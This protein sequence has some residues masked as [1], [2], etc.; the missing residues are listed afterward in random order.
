MTAIYRNT[1][2][3]DLHVQFANLT[4][5]LARIHDTP[6]FTEKHQRAQEI[7]DQLNQIERALKPTVQYGLTDRETQVLHLLAHGHTNETIGGI[8]SLSPLTV[9]THIRKAMNRMGVTSRV[10]AVAVATRLDLFPM[11]LP[12]PTG[13]AS[14]TSGTIKQLRAEMRE[15]GERTITERILKAV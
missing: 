5:E 4:L 10:Q 13:Q 11:T 15:R 6:G 2:E 8:L 7:Q 9:R 14:N 3:Y 12:E 1:P